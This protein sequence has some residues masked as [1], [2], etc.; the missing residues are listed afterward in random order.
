MWLLGFELR[1]SGRAAI[2][3]KTTF[4]I[5]LLNNFSFWNSLHKFTCKHAIY[6]YCVFTSQVSHD[7]SI[8]PS[9]C[10]WEGLLLGLQLE[11]ELPGLQQTQGHSLSASTQ[12]RLQACV[13]GHMCF[14]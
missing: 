4:T 5:N 2:F 6:S 8:A 13:V 7:V 3:I 12:A 10:F 9:P 1:T 11:A 14:G